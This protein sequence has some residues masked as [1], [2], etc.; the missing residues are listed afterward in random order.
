MA[1]PPRLRPVPR[2]DRQLHQAISSGLA[3][4]PVTSK[5]ADPPRRFASLGWSVL[6]FEGI[7]IE[8]LNPWHVAVG[9]ASRGRIAGTVTAPRSAQENDR[10]VIRPDPVAWQRAVDAAWRAESEAI[11]RG[12]ERRRGGL[13][14][15]RRL[16]A[17][18]CG[19]YG[20]GQPGQHHPRLPDG[21]RSDSG[22]PAYLHQSPTVRHRNW[23]DEK[24]LSLA[25]ARCAHHSRR[26]GRM[27]ITKDSAW[28]M[29]SPRAAAT[30]R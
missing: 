19:K 4:G 24:E 12:D 29:I 25:R 15:S 3:K 6:F 2:R 18:R 27:I 10:A 13:R 9:A 23:R 22:R 8:D 20:C 30:A 26:P 7:G 14:N 1:G 21:P 16:R 28:R 5:E 11:L 17:G